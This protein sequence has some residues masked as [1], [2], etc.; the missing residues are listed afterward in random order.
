M[1]QANHATLSLAWETVLAET[2]FSPNGIGR[3]WTRGDPPGED[4]AVL[5]L[6]DRVGAMDEATDLGAMLREITDMVF[7]PAHLIVNGGRVSVL[8]DLVSCHAVPGEGARKLGLVGDWTMRGGTEVPPKL[9]K[10]SGAL[11]SQPAAFGFRSVRAE[12]WARIMDGMSADPPRVSIPEVPDGPGATSIGARI[13]MPVHKKIAALFLSPDGML[14]RDAILV[15][16]RLRATFPEGARARLDPLEAFFR[17]AITNDAP[18]VLESPWVRLD[19]GT[20]PELEDWFYSLLTRGALGRGPGPMT[21]PVPPPQ[22]QTGLGGAVA[23]LTEQLRAGAPDRSAGRPYERFELVAI[24]KTGGSQGP[25]TSY[26]AAD[27]PPF[28]KEF[29]EHRRKKLSIR[30]FVESYI[31][32]VYPEGSIR[33]PFV[34]SSRMLTDLTTLNFAG[35]DT[36]IIHAHRM[37]GFSVFAV[38]PSEDNADPTARRDRMR[39][40]EDTADQHRPADREVM[41][42]LS[43]AAAETPRSRDRLHRWADHFGKMLGVFFGPDCGILP[44]L[45]RFVQLLLSPMYFVAYVPDDYGILLWKLHRAIRGFFLSGTTRWLARLTTDLED[46]TQHT[47]PELLL[48]AALP[49]PPRGRPMPPGQPPSGQPPA[50]RPRLNPSTDSGEGIS[51]KFKATIDRAADAARAVGASFRPASILTNPGVSAALFGSQFIQCVEGRNP[52][53]KKF[54]FGNCRGS[55]N[56]GHNFTS[57]PTTAVVQGMVRRVKV[58]VAA[59]IAGLPQRSPTAPPAPPN[60]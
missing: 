12:P 22:D 43:A 57:Q 38:A 8:W 46:T 18:N 2:M 27:V 45:E 54:I 58:A 13:T 47:P 41:D 3:A 52:C 5:A 30:A 39:A 55:C 26:T 20:S 28:F 24:F 35:G 59:F 6:L 53:G 21:E 1:T 15:T 25:Y 16:N 44:E 49:P 31:D 37:A 42:S 23:A 40:F 56:L 48:R 11:A 29:Q 50:A 10:A 9:M 34:V 4:P 60:A 7:P 32:R 33:Y 14:L 19:P 17:V 36:T 51:D